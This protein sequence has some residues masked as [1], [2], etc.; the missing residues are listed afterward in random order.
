M[1]GDG[2][3]RK[4]QSNNQRACFIQA[5]PRSLAWCISSIEIFQLLSEFEVKPSEPRH[6]FHPEW[7]GW[8]ICTAAMAIC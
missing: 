2:G 8:S 6:L 7:N 4:S 1:C 5:L 3:C